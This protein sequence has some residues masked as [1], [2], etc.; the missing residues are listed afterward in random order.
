MTSNVVVRTL[1]ALLTVSC[2]ISAAQAAPSPAKDPAKEAAEA[3]KP[4][5]P[6]EGVQPD[7]KHVAPAKDPSAGEASAPVVSEPVK[8][9]KQR[10]GR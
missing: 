3:P 8:Q 4:T 5:G 9:P 7:G 1:G 2:L 6:T 10:K